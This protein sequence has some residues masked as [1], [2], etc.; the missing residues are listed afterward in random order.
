MI[1]VDVKCGYRGLSPWY[2]RWQRR[3][4]VI[5]L[6][7]YTYVQY[8]I[9]IYVYGPLPSHSIIWANR[10]SFPDP[11]NLSRGTVIWNPIISDFE[12]LFTCEQIVVGTAVTTLVSMTMAVVGHICVYIYYMYI[13]VY[14]C[15]SSSHV[16]NPHTTTVLGSCLG[17]IDKMDRSFETIDR[18]WSKLGCFY[19]V[20]RPWR[21]VSLW[22]SIDQR[23][24]HIYT[25]TY[26]YIYMAINASTCIL[27]P[28][29]FA[30]EIK[31]TCFPISSS[32]LAYQAF[33]PIPIYIIQSLFLV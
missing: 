17:Y 9:N 8:I 2:L 13:Y 14:L 12:Y 28:V 30:R 18:L 3:W 29:L 33:Y 25:Y 16:W 21:Y 6:L 4:Y 10:V 26:I 15:I 23:L 22:N 1:Y 20:N 5:F 31:P 27:L 24:Y 11:A 7:S 32:S 19:V